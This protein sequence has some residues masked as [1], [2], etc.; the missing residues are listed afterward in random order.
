[1]RITADLVIQQLRDAADAADAENRPRLAITLE[2]GAE[3]LVEA[4]ETVA[5]LTSALQNAE[6]DVERHR[7][8]AKRYHY[9][10]HRAE[11]IA[12]PV[13]PGAMDGL[14]DFCL[15]HDKPKRTLQ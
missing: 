4:I 1:M 13:E 2:T 11:V 9:L 6:A 15:A 14:I 12:N 5:L 7:A 3:F 8:D 10:R